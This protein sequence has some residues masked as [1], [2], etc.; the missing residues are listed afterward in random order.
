MGMFKA[1]VELPRAV[2]EKR[3]EFE[4]I[5]ASIEVKSVKEAQAVRTF[6]R[7]YE[8]HV[9]EISKVQKSGRVYASVVSGSLIRGQL[10]PTPE[11]VIAIHESFGY[12]LLDR[13]SYSIKRH[14]MK[15]PRRENSSKIIEDNV[16][17]FKL[18]S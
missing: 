18:C 1:N 17:I 4:E 3:P 11:A 15:F 9:S 7:D 5:C 8:T 13:F 2:L 14:Y 6:F 16:L 12:K 10:V